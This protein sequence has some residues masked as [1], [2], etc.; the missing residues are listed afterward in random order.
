MAANSSTSSSPM[1]AHHPSPPVLADPP[2]SSPNPHP[3]VSLPTNPNSSIQASIN[4]ITIHNIDS[5]IQTK[6]KRHNYLVWRSLFEPI[7]RRYKLTGIVDGSEPSPPQFL[8]D[9]S[10]RFTSVPNPDYELWYEKDQN[11]IIWIN[12]TLSEDLIP[13]TVGV[14]SAR[15]LWQNLE[16]RFGGVSRSHIHQ[17][18]STLQ[19]AKKGSSSISEYLQRI[20]EATDSLAAAGAPVDDHDLLLII[21]NGLPDEYDS[22]VDSVQFRLVD[23]TVDD[24]HGFLLSKEMALAHKHSTQGT[25]SAPYQAFQSV[26]A[27]S[28]PLLPTPQAYIAQPHPSSN[29]NKGNFQRNNSQRN[30]N[31]RNRYT[32]NHIN[33]NVS[34]REGN[35]SGEGFRNGARFF[36][37]NSRNVHCQI[38]EDTG[39]QAIDCSNRMNPNFQ[40]RIPPAKLAMYARSNASSSPPWLLDS[41]ASSHMTNNLQNLQNPQPYSGP[42]KVYIGDGQ[43]LPILHSGS[44]LLHTPSATFKLQNVLHVPHLKHDLVSANMFLR[45][46]WCSLT[47]NPFDFHVK[48]LTT[49]RMLFRAHVRCGLYPF[50]A[51]SQSS[52][53]HHGLTALKASQHTWHQR[54]G[55]PTFKTL[56]SVISKS[57]LPLSTIVKQSFFCSNCVLGKCAKLPFQNSI[58]H[59]SRSLELVHADVWGPAPL[60]SI[61]GYRFYVIFVDDLTKYTWLYPLKH[62][63]EVFQVFVHFQALVENLSGHKIGTLRCDSGGEFISTQFKQHLS[64]HGIHQHFSCPYTP[65]QNE[66]AERKHRHI[67]ETARTLL[68]ASQVPHQFWVEAFLTAVYLINRLPPTAK[69]SPWEQFFKKKPDYTQLK[70]FGCSCYPWLKPYTQSKLD[71]KSKLCVFIGYS[72]VHKGYRCLDPFTNRVYVSRHVYFDETTFPF[73]NPSLVSQLPSC[74]SSSVNPSSFSLTFP[75]L[76]S[77]SPLTPSITRSQS[78]TSPPVFQPPPSVSPTEFASESVSVPAPVSVPNIVPV[79]DIVPVPPPTLPVST[80]PMQTRSK[81]G[82]FKPKAFT[83]TKHPIPSNLNTEFVPTTYIQASKYPHWRTAMQDEFNALQNTR[84]WTLVPSDPSYN[85]VGCKWVFRIKR[86]PNGSVDRYKTRLVA[87]GYNQQEGIDYSDTFSP[88]TKPVT[89]RLLLTL[90]VQSNWFLHQLDVSNAFLHGSLKENVYMSQP[91]GFI[92]QD[93]SSYVCHL[94]KS[95]Y[96]LKQAPRACFEKLQSA[97]FSM[98]F[99]ASQSDHSLFVLQQPVLVVVLVYVDDILV[100]GPSSTACTNVISQLSDQFPIKD[101]GDLH[102]FLGLEVT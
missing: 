26:P 67:V 83:A 39:H 68:I 3:S 49:G 79:P 87:K 12:S 82:I 46:N 30:Y 2:S 55:H 29:F 5:M 90:A 62:K 85:L 4:S 47:L 9:D 19:S 58:C 34:N 59:S 11:I 94:Q 22:F 95:L 73:H 53:K 97:L 48:D 17:L 102:F 10:G 27:S 89:I 81:S 7:F 77:S 37:N 36:N 60:S 64:S 13:F 44:S 86:N 65:Q 101:L 20:K 1:I 80:H 40:G 14:Q 75:N 32:R 88:V 70:I 35:R 52:S 57:S 41:G 51:S 18:R 24:L 98:G 96:G 74:A 91:P 16:R 78:L 72:L 45:D 71:P 61:S 50:S 8:A 76:Y 42:D 25:N 69:S 63:S 38:C 21:L 15:E 93:K 66:C 31:N 28:P 54:L 100:T 99:K 56:Q 43:G 84:T 23:T 33:K 92:D 6:L